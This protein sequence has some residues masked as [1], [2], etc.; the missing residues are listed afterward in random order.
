MREEKGISQEELANLAEVSLPQ[1]TRIERGVINPTICT[2][3][4]LAKGL[5]VET[6]WLFRFENENLNL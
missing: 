5:D 3:K 6:S 4:S 2:I 1:I